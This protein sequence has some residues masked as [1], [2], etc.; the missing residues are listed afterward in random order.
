MRK[1]T[2]LTIA[3]IMILGIYVLPGVT[4]R[5]AGSHTWE[6]NRTGGPSALQCGKCHQYIQDETQQTAVSR[7]TTLTHQRASNTSNYVGP[8]K[9]IDIQTPTGALD[10]FCTMCHAVEGT[11]TYSGHTRVTIRACTDADC[12]GT[13]TV[14]GINNQSQKEGNFSELTV[15][16]T[17]RL[18]NPADAHARWYN[19]LAGAASTYVAANASQ[20]SG[21]VSSGNYTQGFYACIGC[22]THVSVNMDVYRPGAV[23][24]SINNQGATEFIISAINV[25]T[26]NNNYTRSIGTTGTK[27]N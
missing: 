4:A 19:P 16:I 13:N 17:A 20:P 15:N 12:H 27:W 1:V 22:H 25:D 11:S 2:L 5:I 21:I 8:G 14:I 6:V 3:S 7:N 10:T 24:F 18:S 23:N 26:T 9:F